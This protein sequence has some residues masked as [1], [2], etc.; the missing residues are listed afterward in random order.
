M[1]RL[2][3][4]SKK[5]SHEDSQTA[6]NEEFVTEHDRIYGILRMH[7]PYHSSRESW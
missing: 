1:Y 2:N 7:T 3:G 5:V 6:P 4:Y